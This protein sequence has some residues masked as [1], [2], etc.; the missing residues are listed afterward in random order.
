VTT[1]L[2]KN[3]CW[4]IFGRM[5]KEKNTRTNSQSRLHAQLESA[6]APAIADTLRIRIGDLE[7]SAR[8]ELTAAP[9]TCHLFRQ[10]LPLRKKMIHCSWSGEGVWVPL[11]SW[12]A[13]WCAENQTSRPEPGQL[14]LYASGPSEPE[15]LVPCGACIFN[16]RFGVLTGNHFLSIVDGN[17]KL[18]DLHHLL[19]WKGAQ[20]CFIDQLH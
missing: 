11:G 13:A 17:E 15:L 6:S 5:Q 3:G 10:L 16:S 2:T 9:R 18:L 19:L 12:D 8:W 20:D 1:L 4:Q 7:F 14:L